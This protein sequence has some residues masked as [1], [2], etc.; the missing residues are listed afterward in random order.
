MQK[1]KNRKV[2][3]AFE[4]VGFPNFGMAEVMAK[5]DTG[6]YTG[7]LHCTK[8]EEHKT[9]NTKTLKFS[10]FDQ[11]EITITTHDYRSTHIRSSNG[12]DEKRFVINTEIEIDGQTYP[13]ILSLANRSAMKWPVLIGR[14][15]L[16]KNRFIVDVHQGAKYSEAV[17][18]IKQ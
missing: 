6:A 12:D 7:A 5:I 10:P 11:P 18:E 1:D 15:F 13:I 9:P 17:K 16:R 4:R 8:I 3:G 2:L 14:R